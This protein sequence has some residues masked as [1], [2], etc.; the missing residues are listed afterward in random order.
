MNNGGKKK[1]RERERERDGG[2][3]KIWELRCLCVLC[4]ATKLTTTEKATDT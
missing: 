3:P 1:E 4:I 2:R